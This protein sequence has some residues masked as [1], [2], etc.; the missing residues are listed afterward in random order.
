MPTTSKRTHAEIRAWARERDGPAPAHVVAA[1]RAILADAKRGRLG[2]LL[3][4]EPAPPEPA[5]PE[6]APPCRKKHT[7]DTVYD[8]GQVVVRNRSLQLSPRS[9][10]NDT[11][12]VLVWPQA[13]APLVAG[14]IRPAP[15]YPPTLFAVQT[16]GSRVRGGAHRRGLLPPLRGRPKVCWFTSHHKSAASPNTPWLQQF[17]QRM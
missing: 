15:L 14:R 10:S 4:P 5:P 8:C 9:P 12:D 3:P 6:P 17:A 2:P 16:T 11:R 7:N 1:A 13:S